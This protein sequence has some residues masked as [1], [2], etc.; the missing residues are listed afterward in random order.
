MVIDLS[1]ASREYAE[2]VLVSKEVEVGTVY[3]NGFN[4]LPKSSVAYIS[5]A[6]SS[7][8]TYSNSIYRAVDTSPKTTKTVDYLIG[9]KKEDGILLSIT[10][11]IKYINS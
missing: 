5:N 1:L 6:T 2:V 7:T 8:I 3:E 11:V 9:I 10:G 4:S